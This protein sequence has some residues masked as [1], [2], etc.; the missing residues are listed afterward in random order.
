M[1]HLKEIK[2]KD[3]KEVVFFDIETVSHEEYLTEESPAYDAWCHKLKYDKD[4]ILGED[5]VKKYEEKASLYKEFAKI[6]SISYGRV[7]ANNELVVKKLSGDNEKELIEEFFSDIQ[8]FVAN[9]IPFL[10]GFSIL[11]FDIPFVEFRARV[12]G[13][14][15]IPSFDVG[16]L[17]P[18]NI[19]HVIDIQNL[20]R[21]TSLTNVSLVGLCYALGVPSPKSDIS[22]GDV[23]EVYWKNKDF[24]RIGNYAANDVLATCN[25]FCKYLNIEP[26]TLVFSKVKEKPRVMSALEKLYLFNA[27][28]NDIKTELKD[29]IE[30]NATKEDYNDLFTII[31]GVYV[32]CDFENKD[33]DSKKTIKEKEAEIKDFLDK[34]NLGE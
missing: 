4:V 15:V 8:A 11:Q 20:F 34:L 7:N 25:L 14:T 6:I 27:L 29:A 22:G 26:K 5:V 1:K 16:G 33:Q 23:R 28:T 3:I 18:W 17:A 12:N 31:R 24:E 30:E 21:G 10:S 19:K 32:R 9:D 2:F 13:V